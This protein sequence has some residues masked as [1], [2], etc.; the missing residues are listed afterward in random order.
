MHGAVAQQDKL[1]RGIHFCGKPCMQ[2]S[3]PSW[4]CHSADQESDKEINAAL[5][6]VIRE[7]VKCEE[8]GAVYRFRS[9]GSYW[10]VAC[11]KMCAWSSGLAHH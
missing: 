8:G 1:Y 11:V 3:V 5:T 2:H 7:N 10:R 6:E 4:G 9:L